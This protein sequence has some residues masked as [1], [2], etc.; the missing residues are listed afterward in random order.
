MMADN[1]P[2]SVTSRATTMTSGDSDTKLTCLP[3]DEHVP[4][5]IFSKSVKR[6]EPVNSLLVRSGMPKKGSEGRPRLRKKMGEIPV[7]FPSTAHTKRPAA[8]R[9]ELAFSQGFAHLCPP[10]SGL[11]MSCAASA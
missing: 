6:P 8:A 10:A 2:H 7:F 11:Y 9:A 4:R 5:R 3:N 1:R